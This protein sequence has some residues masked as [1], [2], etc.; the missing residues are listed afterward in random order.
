ML[1]E[2]KDYYCVMCV[3]CFFPLCDCELCSLFLCVCSVRPM[4][5]QFLS[6]PVEVEP[7]RTV[8]NG[9]G[10]TLHLTVRADTLPTIMWRY[11]GVA[12]SEC[13]IDYNI[14]STVEVEQGDGYQYM[15]CVCVCVCV[16][17][18][19][20]RC[21]QPTLYAILCPRAVYSH[22]SSSDQCNVW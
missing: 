10:V 18:Y 9:M 13:N 17:M 7:R 2:V 22:H 15:V 19:K 4:V 5:T 3:L 1:S 8:T 6:M 11:R 20:I 12:I 16:I 21:V 14:S